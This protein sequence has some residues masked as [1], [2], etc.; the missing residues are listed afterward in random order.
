VSRALRF[1]RDGEKG[2]GVGVLRTQRSQERWLRCFNHDEGR[3]LGVGVQAQIP[4]HGKRRRSRVVV[5]S[6]VGKGGARLRQVRIKKT[7]ASK[8]LRMCR[9]T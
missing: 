8:P 3:S 2:S 5:V 9:E 7:N 1:L 6:V 4:N